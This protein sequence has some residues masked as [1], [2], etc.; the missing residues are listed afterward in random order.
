MTHICVSKLTIIGSD[1]GSAPGRRQAIIWTNAGILLIRTLGTIFSEK[2]SGIH[3]FPFKKMH[4]KMSS[5]KLR[6][7]SLGLNVLTLS[8]LLLNSFMNSW[9]LIGNAIPAYFQRNYW[10]NL[11]LIWW[12][13]SLWHSPGL[14]KLSESLPFMSTDCSISF[15]AFEDKLLIRL[16]V[17]SSQ[18]SHGVICVTRTDKHSPWHCWR[19]ACFNL[20]WWAAWS[21]SFWCCNTGKGICDFLW[22][23][24]ILSLVGF[25]CSIVNWCHF[26][27]FNLDH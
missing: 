22:C 12:M 13:K 15:S 8:L 23:I 14:I 26:S 18:D 21:I 11:A 17:N 1:N 3:I 9:P 27:S 24:S 4:L 6:Q 2:L 5:A 20:G 25:C 19:T 7:F 16:W 10:S